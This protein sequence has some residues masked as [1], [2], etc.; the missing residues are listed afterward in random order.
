MRDELIARA[1]ELHTILARASASSPRLF[2]SVARCEDHDDSDVDILVEAGPD[3]SLLDLCRAEA[4]L[5]DRFGRPFELVTLASL[6][7][8]VRSEAVAQAIAL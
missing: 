5:E 1:A 2:G 6:H 7:P 4:E 3:C 8:T